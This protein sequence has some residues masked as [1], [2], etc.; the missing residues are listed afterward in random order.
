MGGLFYQKSREGRF[1]PGVHE[2]STFVMRNGNCVT[3]FQLQ[4]TTSGHVTIAAIITSGE[5]FPLVQGD[6]EASVFRGHVGV[7]GEEVVAVDWSGEFAGGGV[8]GTCCVGDD[9]TETND[10]AFRGVSGVAER[11]KRDD[12][13]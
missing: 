12:G 10:G 4:K 3:G 2:A 1:A 8:V 11:Q 7:H 6:G 13:Y 5:R 9:A